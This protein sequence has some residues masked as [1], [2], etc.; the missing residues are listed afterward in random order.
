MHSDPSA[1]APPESERVAV[2]SA[3]GAHDPFPRQRAV[4]LARRMPSYARLALGPSRDPA[5]SRTRRLAL[6]GAVA[7]LASP[8][9]AIPGLLPVIGQVDDVLVVLLALRFALSGL[10]PE[11]RRHHLILA[12]YRIEIGVEGKNPSRDC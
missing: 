11:Q 5:L 2:P 3:S 1:P 12:N 6:L 9:D 4:E 10:S 8:I 7:Y